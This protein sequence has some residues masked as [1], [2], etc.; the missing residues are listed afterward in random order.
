[1]PYS[2]SGNIPLDVFRSPLEARTEVRDRTSLEGPRCRPC[3][4]KGQSKSG[5]V[6]TRD[7]VGQKEGL[8]CTWRMSIEHPEKKLRLEQ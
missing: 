1:M 3:S 7:K 8:G 2:S 5:E 6:P 4:C